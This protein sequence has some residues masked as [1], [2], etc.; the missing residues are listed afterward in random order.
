MK[1]SLSSVLVAAFCVSVSGFVPASRSTSLSSFLTHRHMFSGA[2]AA[3]PKEDDSEGL[4]Q[5]EK[6]AKAMGM[7]VEEYQLGVRARMK[8]E[9]SINDIRVTGGDKAKGVSVERDGNT[10]SK[11]FII[12]ITDEGKALGKANLERELVAALKSANDQAA[13]GRSSSQQEMMQFIAEEMK[14]MG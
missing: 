2:G 14:T 8:M 13:K 10:P 11:H 7:S 1:T 12:T 4:E 6:M 3:A 5:V 9:E